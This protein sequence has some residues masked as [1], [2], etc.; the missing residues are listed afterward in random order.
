MAGRTESRTRRGRAGQPASPGR[1]PARAALLAYAA[2]VSACSVL[3]PPAI[4][5]APPD[6]T[7]VESGAPSPSAANRDA[8]AAPESP[9]PPPAASPPAAAPPP[10]ASPPVVPTRILVLRASDAASYGDVAASL[11]RLLGEHFELDQISLDRQGS[12]SIGARDAAAAWAAVIAIGA[13]AAAAVDTELDVPTVFCQILDYAPLLALRDTLFGVEAVPPPA[14]QL[15]SW[16]RVAADVR[17]VGTLVAAGQ[18]ELADRARRA[19]AANGLE[20]HV[21]FA[22]SDREVLYRFRRLAS[23]V[24]GFWLLPNSEILSP[25]VLREVL[26]YARNRGLHSVVFDDALLEWGGLLSVASDADDVAATVARVVEALVG[27]NAGELDRVTPLTRAEV[28]VNRDVAAALGIAVPAKLSR[29]G[30]RGLAFD[31]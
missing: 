7:R 17:S 10:A 2:I 3:G 14:L 21:E 15:E 20:L 4:E 28:R 27:G 23:S 1:A 29:T 30:S 24:D 18:D 22:A 12:A 5:P 16:K 8:A 26:D 25:R 13:D 9:A 19:A 11:E 31:R 6:E